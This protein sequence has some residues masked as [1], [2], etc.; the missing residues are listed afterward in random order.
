[1]SGDRTASGRLVDD[2]MMV[3]LRLP[4]HLHARVR[5]AAKED[6]RPLN[7]WITLQLE[8]QLAAGAETP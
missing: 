2:R 6:R 1:M 8:K 7:T 3:T 5:A 4:S